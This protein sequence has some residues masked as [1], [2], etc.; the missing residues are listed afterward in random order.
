MYAAVVVPCR[1]DI[2]QAELGNINIYEVSGWGGC[3]CGGGGKM[4]P[5]GSTECLC[6]LRIGLGVKLQRHQDKHARR[7][8][9]VGGWACV[10]SRQ[11]QQLT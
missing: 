6:V 3:V 1:L 5:Q 2:A 11:L 10:M 8:R 9:D 7:G 4:R